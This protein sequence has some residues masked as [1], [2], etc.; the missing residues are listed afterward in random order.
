MSNHTHAILCCCHPTAACPG[1]PVHSSPDDVMQIR[2]TRHFPVDLVSRPTPNL[3]DPFRKPALHPGM[4]D[5]GQPSNGAK[6]AK[7]RAEN[8]DAKQTTLGLI[9]IVL[10]VAAIT[11]AILALTGSL[12]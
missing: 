4:P 1:C 8:A 6:H 9:V 2:P 10:V 11:T 12:G 5:P 3:P 7:I